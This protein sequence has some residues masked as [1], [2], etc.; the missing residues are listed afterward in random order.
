MVLV[1]PLVMGGSA[2][3]CRVS[4]S[5]AFGMP[6]I[7]IHPL[8]SLSRNDINEKGMVADD[9]ARPKS[10]ST[11]TWCPPQLLSSRVKDPFEIRVSNFEK[12][13]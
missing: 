11:S 2:I 7:C 6:F 4:L 9:G 8:E 10:T 13:T 5:S 1:R 12:Q 3:F